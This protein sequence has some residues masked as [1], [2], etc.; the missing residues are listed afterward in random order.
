[1]KVPSGAKAYG[2]YAALAKDPNV[3]AIYVATPHSHHYQNVMLCLENGK[4]VLCEKSFTVNAPQTERL[5]QIA[6]EKKLFLMEAV[7]TRFFPLSI[8]IRKAIENGEI[9]QVLRTFADLSM[10][11]N[12]EKDLGTK[13]RQV[14][15][16]LAGGAM[17]D[18]ARNP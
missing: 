18:C 13:H 15:M 10:A 12:V 6:R 17:L 3:D 1:M 14:N 4:H 11:K 5:V 8:Q 16:D 2:D 9:G 7:W